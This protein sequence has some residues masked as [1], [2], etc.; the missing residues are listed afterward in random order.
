MINLYKAN[1]KR[2]TKN[3]IFIGGCI[4]AFLAT[5][6]FTA[7]LM[8][9]TGR[10]EEMGPDRRMFF[11][12]IAM[13]VFST[14]FVPLYTNME[15]RFGVIRNKIAAGYSQKQVYFS[16]LL[17]HITAMAI[18]MVCYLLGGILGGARDFGK[19]FVLNSVLFFALCGYIGVMMLISFR[20]L[21][22][23][24]LSIAAFLILNVCYTGTMIGNALLS[25]VLKGVAKQVGVIIYNMT[26]F[27]QWISGT[28]FSDDFVN[29][30]RPQQIVIS[31]AV[32]LLTI[33]FAT[34]GL[35]KR[36]LQ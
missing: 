31:I 3:F 16:Q 27:G 29:P 18:M 17:G 22:V 6:A 26:A 35:E 12:S 14:I 10:F 9:M 32:L 36:D 7:N 19:M 15:Y 2:I 20:I 13:M 28:G 23:V 4:I 8:R 5:F 1:I 33:F 30:G 21:K 34:L 24:A 11:I 25:F